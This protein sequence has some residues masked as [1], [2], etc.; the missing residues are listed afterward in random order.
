MPTIPI[1]KLFGR[2]PISPLQK[3]MQEVHDCV[4][5][6]VPFFEAVIEKDWEKA[7]EI[8]QQIHNLE[9]SADAIK[10]D[11]R[12]KL[13]KGLFLP[14][15]R[16]AILEL[17]STQD[18][19]ANKAKDIAG[20]VLGRRMAFPKIIRED[21]LHFLNRCVEASKQANKAIHE[22]DELL[23][24]GFS[25]SEITILAAMINKLFTIEDDTDLLQIEIRR[26]IFSIEAH[27]PPV[28]II[29]L[30]KIIEWTGDLANRAQHVGDRLQIL[31]AR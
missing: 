13:P 3:H 24:S 8:R 30:Y 23:E 16:V 12:L 20:L 1:F 25:G 11:L 9:N 2:S 10:R 4:K 27:S 7:D 17:I 15:S 31:I 19:L 6:L 29:F 26:K 21:Y 5:C 14:V 28:D 18:S 22:L